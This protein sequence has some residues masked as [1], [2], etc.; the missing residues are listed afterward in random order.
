[1]PFTS[2]SNQYSMYT[3]SKQP[4]KTAVRQAMRHHLGYSYR[5]INDFYGVHLQNIWFSVNG[6]CT[7]SWFNRS[8][9][10]QELAIMAANALVRC[11]TID[12]LL[13]DLA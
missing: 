6:N 10:E 9:E 2:K 12:K 13:V 1:M 7:T 5:R 11:E 4:S 8:T 3:T